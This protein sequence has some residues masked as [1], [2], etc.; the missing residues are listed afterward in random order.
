MKSLYSNWN[1]FVVYDIDVMLRL[2]DKFVL[3]FYHYLVQKEY[4]ADPLPNYVHITL[5]ICQQNLQL[6]RHALQ[7]SSFGEEIL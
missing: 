2:I 3:D 6:F 7:T 1:S 5:I 4:L